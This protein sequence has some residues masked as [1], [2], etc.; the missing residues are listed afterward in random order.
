MQAIQYISNRF[1]DNN[2]YTNWLNPYK[3]VTRHIYLQL[4]IILGNKC[5]FL[6]EFEVNNQ[7]NLI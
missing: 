4:W 7:I 6:C 1:Q 3:Y 5:S 2:K